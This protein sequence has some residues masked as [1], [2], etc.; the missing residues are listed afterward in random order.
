MGIRIPDNAICRAIV[1]ELGHPII[2][3]SANRSGDEPIGNPLTVD[4]ELGNDLDLVVDGGILTADVS[5]VVSLIGDAASV[6][7]EGVGDVSWCA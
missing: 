7:R 5:S 4:Q 3:T 6:L 1:T 2:T